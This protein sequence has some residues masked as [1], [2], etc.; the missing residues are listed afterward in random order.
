MKETMFLFARKVKRRYCELGFIETIRYS[1]MRAIDLIQEHLFDRIHNVDTTGVTLPI[2]KGGQGY[3]GSLPQLVRRVLRDV[4]V[5]YED[6]TFI[7]LGSGKGRTLLIASEFPFRRIIGVE[8]DPMLNGIAESNLIR[9]R[10][11]R[12]QCRLLKSV[13]G[14]VRDFDFALEPLMIYLFNPFEETVL[15]TIL[16][17]VEASLKQK[18]RS[19][20]I[21]YLRPLFEGLVEQ[22]GFLQSVSYR[23]NQFIRNYSYAV[24]RNVQYVA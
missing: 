17:N 22:A 7:D 11:E 10:T 6:Y 21:V 12:Q 16:Q 9:Y 18:P 14:D 8:V 19:V 20:L 23:R 24:Y 4:K 2:V 3:K 5:P 13:C 15:R 1:T